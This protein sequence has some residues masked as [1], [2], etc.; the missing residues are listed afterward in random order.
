MTPKRRYQHTFSLTDQEEVDLLTVTCK[1][2]VIE[3]IR[4]GIKEL[5]K[6]CPEPSKETVEKIK[7]LVK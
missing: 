3:I 2:K 6:E 7:N 5:L 4:K 1:F